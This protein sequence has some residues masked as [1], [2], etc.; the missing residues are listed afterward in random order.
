MMYICYIKYLEKYELLCSL[1]E[2]ISSS[3]ETM[4]LMWETVRS[5]HSEVAKRNNM[6]GLQSH[7]DKGP[8]ELALVFW[9]HRHKKHL[10][11]SLFLLYLYSTH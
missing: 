6:G 10:I 8:D 9:G 7:I 11:I 4:S 3:W 2:T 1:S 5:C